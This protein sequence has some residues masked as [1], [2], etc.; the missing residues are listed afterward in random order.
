MKRVRLT[1]PLDLTSE[2]T[3]R[4]LIRSHGLLNIGALALWGDAGWRVVID[5][6][7]PDTVREYLAEHMPGIEWTQGE[8][9]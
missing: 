7:K 6:A 5:T 2:R 9:T 1:A 3:A 8:I 4:G